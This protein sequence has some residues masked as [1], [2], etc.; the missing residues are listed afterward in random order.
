MDHS[1]SIL[2]FDAKG[3]L[4]EPVGYQEDFDRVMA[5]LHRLLSL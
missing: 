3:R 4:F 1:V 5:K 2:L